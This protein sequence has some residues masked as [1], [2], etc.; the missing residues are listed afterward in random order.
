MGDAT[1]RPGIEA[2]ILVLVK[3]QSKAVDDA[4]FLG[5][6]PAESV[7]YEERYQRLC[8]LCRQLAG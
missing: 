7:A 1:Q 8:W 2:E 3:K 6:D 4:G 5:W